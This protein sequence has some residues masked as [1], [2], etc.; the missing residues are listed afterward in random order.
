MEAC[1][2]LIASSD[3]LTYTFDCDKYPDSDDRNICEDPTRRKDCFENEFKC[4]DLSCIP[5]QWQCDNIKDCGDGEDE[6][7]CLICNPEEF[8]CRS[9]EKCLLDKY[10]C[11]MNE[12][13]ADGSDERDCFS[14]NNDEDPQL[15]PRIFSFASYLLPNFTS[16]NSFTA[17]S[18]ED[19]L[20]SGSELNESLASAGKNNRF[21]NG[22]ISLH[23]IQKGNESNANTN[24]TRNLGKKILY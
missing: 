6:L 2:S 14:E 11:D 12:D 13:C 3:I 22:S 5:N 7:G 19:R 21:T 18:D 15:Y 17:I 4:E 23:E 9:N 20:A 8:R 10:R 1:S 16:E 24:I